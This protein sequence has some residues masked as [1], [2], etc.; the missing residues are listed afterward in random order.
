MAVGSAAYTAPELLRNEGYGKGADWWALGILIFELLTGGTP[1]YS[2]NEA[3]MFANILK[4]KYTWPADVLADGDID[5]SVQ[6]IVKNLL[7]EQVGRRLGCRTQGKGTADITGHKWLRS[8]PWETL[9]CRQLLPPHHPH[10][11]SDC[12]ATYY[13]DF[14]EGEGLDNESEMITQPSS[15]THKL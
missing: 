7:H 9:A 14:K 15:F 6:D 11:L 3:V 12:D 5:K 10:P 2:D 8:F 1:F 4:G 13:G